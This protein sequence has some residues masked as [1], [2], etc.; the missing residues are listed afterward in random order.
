VFSGNQNLTALADLQVEPS[1]D[2]VPASI[3]E[4]AHFWKTSESVLEFL[5]GEIDRSVNPPVIVSDV[6]IGDDKGTL[7]SPLV[8]IRTEMTTTYYELSHELHCA[9]TLYVLAM[10]ADRLHA[11]QGVV[12]QYLAAARSHLGESSSPDTDEFKKSLA[13][14][15]QDKLDLLKQSAGNQ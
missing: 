9:L 15:V 10:E 2:K 14:A 4:K 6:Y 7:P 3:R 13:K 1:T 11:D 5:S 12:S 8:T